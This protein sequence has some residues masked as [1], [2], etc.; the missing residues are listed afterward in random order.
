MAG[1]VCKVIINQQAKALSASLEAILTNPDLHQG[2]IPDDE[3]LSLIQDLADLDIAAW[4]G[5]TT[6][7]CA[8]GLLGLVKRLEG[9]GLISPDVWEILPEPSGDA[10]SGGPPGPAP[11]I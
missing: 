10:V 4:K 2:K 6:R 3:C 7:V 5:D 1:P 8:G 11:G 9:Y